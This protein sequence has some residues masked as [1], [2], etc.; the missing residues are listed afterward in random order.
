MG[1]RAIVREMMEIG[2]FFGGCFLVMFAILLC[3]GSSNWANHET[4]MS[5]EWFATPATLTN[6]TVERLC[7]RCC[8]TNGEKVDANEFRQI[9]SFVAHLENTTALS[10]QMREI[11]CHRNGRPS[12]TGWCGRNTH[13]PCDGTL[14]CNA[15]SCDGKVLLQRPEDVAGDLAM[16][17]TFTICGALGILSLAC[18]FEPVRTTFAEVIGL[19]GSCNDCCF[20]WCEDRFDDVRVLCLRCQPGRL[21]QQH[22]KVT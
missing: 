14:Y 1:L 5:D 8:A 22:D 15:E 4:I 3:V 19:V 17:I 6:V 12:A 10:L 11:S 18:C 20:G 2:S 9:W 13:T 21:P 7:T 16:W